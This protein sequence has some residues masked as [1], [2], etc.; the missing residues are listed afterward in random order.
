MHM[1]VGREIGLGIMNECFEN[2][3]FYKPKTLL[4]S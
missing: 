1:C 3:Y 4:V 2:K